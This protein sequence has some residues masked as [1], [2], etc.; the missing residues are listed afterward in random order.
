[1]PGSVWYRT[2]VRGRSRRQQDHLA[3]VEVDGTLLIG[4]KQST[5]TSPIDLPEPPKLDAS[6]Q[7]MAVHGDTVLALST[8]T[9]DE[10]HDTLV[11][12][13]GAA[14]GRE[15]NDYR[16]RRDLAGHPP[17]TWTDAVT[18]AAVRSRPERSPGRGLVASDHD[19]WIRG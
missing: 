18:G 11:G 13:T 1:V 6:V 3:V 17:A 19:L 14:L 2:A 15:R 9:E 12:W 7:A 16:M 4:G 10:Q 5:P 8:E